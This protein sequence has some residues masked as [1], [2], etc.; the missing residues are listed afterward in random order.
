MVIIMNLNKKG[1]IN[2]AV[3]YSMLL[4][5]SITLLLI[6]ATLTNEHENN[7]EFIDDINNS[8]TECINNKEC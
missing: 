3:I 7:N 2:S 5:I 4:L 8:L 6:L 1:F